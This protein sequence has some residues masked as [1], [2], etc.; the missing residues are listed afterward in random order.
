[1]RAEAPCT[2][3]RFFGGGISLAHPFFIPAL[4]NDPAACDHRWQLRCFPCLVVR[5]RTSCPEGQTARRHA[6]GY[7][8]YRRTT[9]TEG[10]ASRSY[11]DVVDFLLWP[12]KPCLEPRFASLDLGL[13]TLPKRQLQRNRNRPSMPASCTGP[14]RQNAPLRMTAA[15]RGGAKRNQRFSRFSK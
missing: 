3:R 12:C 7:R 10:Q 6:R 2:S 15:A 1:M 14:S 4:R 11:P 9:R 13:R 8:H 5:Y